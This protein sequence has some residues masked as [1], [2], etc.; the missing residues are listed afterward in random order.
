MPPRLYITKIKENWHGK[1]NQFLL[2]IPYTLKKGDVF[3]YK[4]SFT[5]VEITIRDC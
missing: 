1:K 4:K 5:G 3:S 2:K